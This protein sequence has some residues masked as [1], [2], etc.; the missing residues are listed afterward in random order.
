MYQTEKYPIV[1]QSGAG[2]GFYDGVVRGSRISEKGYDNEG[3]HSLSKSRIPGPHWKKLIMVN[4]N[5]IQDGLK[6]TIQSLPDPLNQDHFE[7]FQKGVYGR[8]DISVYL[9]SQRDFAFLFPQT[10]FDYRHYKPRVEALKLNQYKEQ[11]AILEK[12]FEK[13]KSYFSGKKRVLEVGGG[14]GAFLKLLQEKNPLL[15]LASL[16]PDLD[17]RAGRQRIEGLSQYASFDGLLGQNNK[18]EVVCLFHVLEH[19]QDPASFLRSC[20]QVLAPNGLIVAEIPSLDDPLIKLYDSTAYRDFYFQ[21]QHP[22]VYSTRS[23]ARLLESNGFILANMIPHQRYGLENHLTWLSK[24]KPGGDEFL[25]A[26]FAGV[27]E[28]YRKSLETMGGTD[29]LIFV[30]RPSRE[31][32]DQ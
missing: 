2:V 17:S 6:Q 31:D 12:R 29:S 16:E 32:V 7:E 22:Y 19:I 26:A 14:D 24:G 21:A 23:I 10:Q 8:P 20:A 25:R 9:N 13:I 4:V 5:I 11:I 15:T 18:F 30:I 28:A 3:G 27:D 1:N